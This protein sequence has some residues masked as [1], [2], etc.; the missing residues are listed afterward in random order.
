M[1]TSLAAYGA[2]LIA[3]LF[4]SW[5]LRTWP[6]RIAYPGDRNAGVE[7]IVLA[8]SL[9][10]REG[11]P[12]YS[13]D[14]ASGFH[15][16]AYGPLHYLLGSRL[17][18][19]KHP[20]YLGF[21]ILGALTTLGS[22]A[23]CGVLAFWVSGSWLAALLA[24]LIYLSFAVVSQFELTARSDSS[25]LF[26]S[27]AAFLV[28]YRFRESRLLLL[29]V[30]LAL[31]S[32]FFK[33]Q[34]VAGSAALFLYLLI[35]KR[36]RLAAAFASLMAVGWLGLMALFE[37]AVF[38]GQNFA[39]HYFTY[40]ATTFSPE[41]FLV[42]LFLFV[43]LAAIPYVVGWLYLREHPDWALGFYMA[44]ALVLFLIGFSRHGSDRNYFVDSY[45]ISSS[46]L[47]AYLVEGMVNRRRLLRRIIPFL[48]I[49]VGAQLL[50]NPKTPQP[51]DF[52]DDQAIQDYL[53][54]NF[55]SHSQGL[56]YCAGD[57]ARAGLDVPYTDL[58]LFS[59]LVERGVISDE[60][61]VSQV[62]Q[63]R[64]ALIG[65]NFDPNQEKDQERMHYLLPEAVLAA[66]RQ[67]Y[68]LRDVLPM[69][70]PERLK[71]PLDRFYVFVPRQDA[72]A[73]ESP[74][75]SAPP[76]GWKPAPAPSAHGG[77][78]REDQGLLRTAPRRRGKLSE[79]DAAALRS[80]AA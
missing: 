75:P 11:V 78:L 77:K 52:V 14:I 64:F 7:G 48:I 71:R 51:V 5:N 63:H 2:C 74:Q 41:R 23:A 21:R 58:F 60:S 65:L 62:R 59:R 13:A 16:S 9:D 36:Y 32:Y 61:L 37:Y 54:A 24:P 19:P 66:V 72:S 79:S 57:L 73:G 30:P 15:A 68:R 46:L 28:G 3:A 47:S 49:L 38:P 70:E 53:R 6:S 12:I 26:L 56:S 25:A 39:R 45:W 29:S 8:E 10:L 40:I 44:C 69:P 27:F 35:E 43:L 67:G 50:P 17:I 18:D 1:R 22:A 33:Q 80:G 76:A 34:F 31:A 42:S 4:A 55:P 20:G